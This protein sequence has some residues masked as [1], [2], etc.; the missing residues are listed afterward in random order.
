ML[1][2][3]PGKVYYAKNQGSDREREDF[4]TRERD[5]WEGEIFIFNDPEFQVSL[6]P[7][8]PVEVGYAP[9]W[10]KR[11][12]LSLDDYTKASNMP[13]RFR[14]VF[15]LLGICY[16]LI[17]WPAY[18]K[19]ESQGRDQLRTCS[20][21]YRKEDVICQ[22]AVGLT[23][24]QAKESRGNLRS[25]FRGCRFKASRENSI[26]MPYKWQLID[27]WPLARVL[28]YMQHTVGMIPMA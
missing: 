8:G 4:E 19:A 28:C 18:S 9:Y 21:Y 26:S 20:T 7:S 16:H 23:S 11:S 5:I 17:S 1:N 3:Q 13:M 24:M 2:S 22:K 25:G 15:A 27:I 12:S 14:T 10:K 6:K